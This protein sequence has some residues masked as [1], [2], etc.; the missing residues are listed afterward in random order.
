MV[1]AVLREWRRSMERIRFVFMGW[2]ALKAEMQV[3]M[4]W[5]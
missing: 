2:E 4:V 3:R 5:M 1:Q